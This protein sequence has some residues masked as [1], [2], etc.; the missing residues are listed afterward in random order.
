MGVVKD[1]TPF[2]KGRRFRIDIGEIA[3]TAQVGQS[4][5]VNGVCLTATSLSGSV[6]TFDAVSETVSR[7]NLGL[8][9]PGGK[10]NLEPALKAGD[11]LDGHIM[12]GHVDALANVV[13]VEAA[14]SDNRVL[15]IAL[16]K[17]IRHLVAE[18]GSVAIDGISLTV[19]QA[20]DDWFTVAV[21]P[22]TWGHT[23]LSLLKPG[24]GV[25]L[26][27][28]VMARYAARILQFEGGDQGIS[29]D[30]LR[31]NGFA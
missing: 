1:S 7:S 3:D 8:L 23:T 16:P 20:G 15:K 31:R 25:N 22:L 2:G 14:S 19:A 21:I 5:A 6:A 4:I 13:S 27:A 9:K 30:F 18:K 28:D 26:E 12:L 29:E 24:S 10:V 17:N 11:A